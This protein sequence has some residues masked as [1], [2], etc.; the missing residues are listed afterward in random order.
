MHYICVATLNVYTDKIVGMKIEAEIVQTK[1]ESSLQKAIVNIIF[2]NNWLNRTMADRLKPFDMTVQQYN[3]LRI[4]RGQYPATATISLLQERMLD[5]MSNA[6][7]LVEKLVAKSLVDRKICPE[8]R[9][10][11]Q[12]LI[13]DKGLE[14]LAILKLEINIAQIGEDC[15]EDHELELLSDLLDRLRG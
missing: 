6:S 15:L 3:I 7:R 9:R 4:L 1:F 13:T 8:D 2:T 5:K 11:V 10:Q 12:V 14:L